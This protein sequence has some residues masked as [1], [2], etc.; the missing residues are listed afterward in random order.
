MDTRSSK[1][2]LITG[3]ALAGLYFALAPRSPLGLALRRW[4]GSWM[5]FVEGLVGLSAVALVLAGYVGYLFS[6]YPKGYARYRSLTLAALLVWISLAEAVWEVSYGGEGMAEYL[7]SLL[8]TSP[9][10]IVLASYIEK[11]YKPPRRLVVV[12]TVRASRRG[13]R[14]HR[15]DEGGE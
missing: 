3:V 7:V 5:D 2:L 6:R 13:S 4:A 12:A 14:D 15:G 1:T 11:R 8:L 9:V 10:A